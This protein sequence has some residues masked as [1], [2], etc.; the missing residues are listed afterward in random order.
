MPVPERRIDVEESDGVS[1][2]QHRVPVGVAFPQRLT[3]FACAVDD[4]GRILM[5][6]HER[7]GVLRWE[8]PGGHV[9]P[10]ESLVDAVVRETRRP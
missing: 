2:L 10:G 9:D 4:Q 5:L 6:R 1:L 3:G 7:L 8:L